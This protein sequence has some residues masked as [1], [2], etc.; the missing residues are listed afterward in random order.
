[1][2]YDARLMRTRIAIACLL[3]VACGPKP[4]A[5]VTPAS[6]ASTAAP[7]ATTTA[8]PA[9]PPTT[10]R[11]PRTFLPTRYT[12]RLAID[13]AQDTFRGAVAIAGTLAERTSLIWLHGWKLT[14][15]RAVARQGGAEV[16]LTVTPRGEDLLEIRAATP[17]APGAWTL[18][19][20]YAAL[21]D[22]V[23]TTGAFKQ[24]V[25]G[26]PYVF[27][28]LE[29]IYAR[30]VFPCVDEP[31]R[32]V[33]WQ[34]TFDIPSALTVVGNTPQV[35]E[36]PLDAKTKR[37]ELAVSKP[38]PSY[39]VAFGVGP[40]DIVDAGKTRRGTPVRMVT[41]ARRGPD[42][43]Y[44]AQTTPRLV[45]LAEDW[46]GA[47]YPYEKLDMLTIPLTIGF[48]AMENAGLITFT[49]TLMLMD[50][51]P[52]KER[53]RAWVVVASHEI[54]HQW[55]GDLVTP[56][57]WDDIWLNEGFATWL[58]YKLS[59]KF[60]PA[61]RDDESPID[62]RHY[63][64][65]S[66]AL[67][68]ARKIRQP[69]EEPGD[70]LN[71]FDGISYQKGASV[72]RMFERYVGL[73]RF[74]RGVREYLESRAW[75]N[76]TS[77][78]FVAAIS[79]AAGR[80]IDA[81]FATFLEQAGA[82][83]ITAT[84]ACRGGKV[85]LQLAQQRYVP[86]GA[87]TPAAGTPWQ[88]PVCV[89]YDKGGTRAETCTLLDQPAATIALDAKT[90]PRWVM[91]N[92]HGAGYYRNAYTPAQIRALRDEAWGQLAWTERRVLFFDVTAAAHTGKLP[93]QVALSFVPK[94][95]AGNDRFTVE[96]AVDLPAALDALVPDELRAKYEHWMRQQFG[97]AAAAVGLA[98]RA[99]ESLDAETVRTSLVGTSA[100]IAREPALVAEAVKLG[101][102]WRELPEAIRGQVLALAVDA[103]PAAFERALRDVRTEPDRKRRDDLFEALAAVR[104][105]ARKQRALALVID[106]EVDIRESMRI[107]RR[108]SNDVT[109][110]VAQRFFR[111]HEG[112][113][114][115][116]VPHAETSSPL[117]LL[118]YLFTATCKAD[119]RDAIAA[120]VTKT[121][122]PM[123][124]GARVVRQAIE[125]MEQCI[126]KRQ[127]LEPEIRAWLSGV[128]IP[129]PR[130]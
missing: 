89:A 2:R 111:E 40:F 81:A 13:P 78:D 58:A 24:T 98:P 122:A 57:F 42:A 101:D 121:F 63:A 91:P 1:M 55:F 94:L 33:P 93:L 18:E 116:R 95:L 117:A 21:L 86:P 50:K 5:S 60:E 130:K 106:P 66:D 71:V 70:I 27:T 25:A 87:P 112:A 125:G 48:G 65:A 35:R 15:A 79:K 99:G 10:V 118:A 74:Q 126:A 17:L 64:L 3:F 103:N 45:E 28:Q 49:E 44:A 97:A 53:Q 69:I 36:T 6:V 37:V 29:A 12:A 110:A 76:A 34:L 96:P 14:I 123:A 90:C 120:Y 62:G 114:L 11:L 16:A 119:Q 85:E 124:G 77:A 92:A 7:P 38:L 47:P 113:I 83:E 43:A 104:D 51:Q 115:A 22:N 127:I 41:L 88:V 20:D 54:A 4:T 108:S 30:R 9:T 109:R 75:S 26:Q 128:R 105:P 52:S 19:L 32:K 68:S 8:E 72:L 73:D 23:N 61:W 46:F 59:A 82:P 129:K 102:R 100:W 84:T 107:L 56:V 67:V 39:L 80:D 31:D